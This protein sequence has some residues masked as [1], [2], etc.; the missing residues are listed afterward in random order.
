MDG[1]QLGAGSLWPL[2]V[3]FWCFGLWPVFT[4][5][6]FVSFVV[7]L[8]PSGGFLVCLGNGAD[9]SDYVTGSNHIGGPLLPALLL[10]YWTYMETSA[11]YLG[12]WKKKT[13]LTHHLDWF[14]LRQKV[15]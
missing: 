4:F 6:P 2:M 8:N 7:L 5:F 12:Y 10:C 13:K 3:A 1:A 14:W 11:T 9:Q 15:N